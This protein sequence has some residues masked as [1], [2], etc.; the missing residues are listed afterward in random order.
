MKIFDADRDSSPTRMFA[1]KD[2]TGD[3]VQAWWR[4]GT[5]ITAY[6]LKHQITNVLQL[7]AVRLLRVSDDVM[8]IKATV[9]A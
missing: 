8:R 5:S 6:I 7:P 9:I 3:S 4:M 1:H 2:C